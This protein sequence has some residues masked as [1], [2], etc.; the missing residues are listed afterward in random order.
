M[1]NWIDL[2]ESATPDHVAEINAIATDFRNDIEPRETDRGYYTF[3]GKCNQYSREL[4]G[5]LRSRGYD[6]KSILGHYNVK[7]QKFIDAHGS[8]ISGW[9][10]GDWDEFP[11]EDHEY[12][13]V[14]GLIV[15]VTSDQFNPSNPHDHRVVVTTRNDPRYR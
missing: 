13:I 6:A 4:A 8:A 5:I 2:F 3:F 12:T 10:E 11:P 7:D 1:R 14:D 15:D 9:D